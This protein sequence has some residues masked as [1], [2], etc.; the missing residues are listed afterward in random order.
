MAAKIKE[1]ALLKSADIETKEFLKPI[2]KVAIFVNTCQRISP[3]MAARIK[4]NALLKSADIETKEFLKPISKV[5]FFV[6]TS[7]RISPNRYKYF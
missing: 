6:N 5:A 3:N 7:Q 1:N 4:E 2:S